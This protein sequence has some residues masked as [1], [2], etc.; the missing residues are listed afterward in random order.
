MESLGIISK[1]DTP[2]PWCAGMAVVP[3]KDKTVR[4][5]VD[6]KPLNQSVL[7]ETHPLLKVDDTLAQLTN[8]K[9]FSKLDANSGFWQIPL[10]EKSWHLTTFLTSFGHFW[11]SHHLTTF[12]APFGCFCFNKMPFGISSAPEHFQKQMNEI[13]SGLPGV[14]CLIDDVLVYGSIQEEHD[15]HLQAVLE[16]IQSAG[17]T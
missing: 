15:K 13:L 2:T 16:R 8:A 5:C 12:L 3:K 1:V 14:V 11:R 10:A 7:R 9:V 4:I 17:A 6:L